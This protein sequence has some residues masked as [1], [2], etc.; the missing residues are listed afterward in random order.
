[1]A[2]GGV[3]V[4]LLAAAATPASARE[5][6]R[7]VLP[8]GQGETVDAGELAAAQASGEPPASFTN[9]NGMYAGLVG[10]APRLRSAD[11]DRYFKPE[12]FGPP[13]QPASE[14]SPRPGVRIARD[15]FNVP[16]VTGDTRADTMFGAGYAT[17]QD[18]LFLMDVLRHTG[19]GRL[20]ELIGPGTDD[21]NVKADAEQLKI[22]DYSDDE[23]Q[24]MIDPARAR[25]PGRRARSSRPT[26]TPTSPVSTSTSPRRAPTRPSCPPSTP[27]SARCPRTG[28][29]PTRSRSPR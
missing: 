9:Q 15:A 5:P 21:A 2:T 13:A 11:L 17:A 19:R 10:A 1:M 29:A 25:P 16:H 12:T 22:A 20:T 8:A 14:V 23:L 6:F 28:R 26:S 7:N 3:V 27:H 18:R 4:A 24:A